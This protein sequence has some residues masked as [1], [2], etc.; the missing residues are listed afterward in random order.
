M[1]R[2]YQ[3]DYMKLASMVGVDAKNVKRVVSAA[4]LIVE[5]L[6]HLLGGTS[7]L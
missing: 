1:N 7:A 3:M 5:S 6:P 2:R 4:D